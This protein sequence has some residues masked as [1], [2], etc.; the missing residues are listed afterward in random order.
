MPQATQ[1]T[2]E[3]QEQFR[4]E[5]QDTANQ[6]V[7]ALQGTRPSFVVMEA[8]FLVHRYTVM[9]LPPDA[10]SHVAMAVGAYAG[11]LLQHSAALSNPPAGG[12][13]AVH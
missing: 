10:I 6:I 8:L 1:P 5:A 9:Q 7:Q 4:L 3:Q 13:A 12:S 11:E 2:P